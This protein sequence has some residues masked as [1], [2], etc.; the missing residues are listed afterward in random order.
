M[1]SGDAPGKPIFDFPKNTSS[2]VDVMFHQS[3]PAIFRPA[4]SVVIANYILVIWVRILCQISL[5]KFPGLIIC[6]LEKNVKMVNIPQVNS[7][8]MLC[9]KF[10]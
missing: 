5:D 7:D 4:F 1:D 2:K 3:H 6:E 10:Y 9:F 8:R